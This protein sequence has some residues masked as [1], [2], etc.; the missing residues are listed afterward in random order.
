MRFAP[1][2]LAL[3]ALALGSAVAASAA[4]TERRVS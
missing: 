2:T 1:V 3:A 4:T